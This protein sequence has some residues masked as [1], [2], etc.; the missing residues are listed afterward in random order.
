MKIILLLTLIISS[1]F[2]STSKKRYLLNQN[3]ITFIYE[4][5]EGAPPISCTH[6]IKNENNPYD[7][8]VTCE[9]EKQKKEFIVHLALSQYRR[10]H[11]PKTSFELLY[12]VDSNG[13]TTWFHLDQATN[14]QFL[15]S[16]QSITDEMA[17]LRLKIKLK[18]I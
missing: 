11:Q 12:W 13:A 10:D 6:K 18:N 15:E 5:F 17:A 14:L 16:S 8:Q 9:D 3:Q 2:A 7:L 1:V 4:P